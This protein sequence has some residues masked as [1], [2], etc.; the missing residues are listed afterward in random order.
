VPP[1]NNNPPPYII[2][3][4]GLLLGKKG[5]RGINHFVITL[6]ATIQRINDFQ[7]HFNRSQSYLLELLRPHARET[8]RQ[9]PYKQAASF[10]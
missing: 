4:Q 2:P 8:Y 3:T 6:A 5:S 7:I 1:L 9:H 10:L